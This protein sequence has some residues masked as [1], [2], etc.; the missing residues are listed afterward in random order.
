MNDSQ[1]HVSTSDSDVGREFEERT[2]KILAQ[3]GLRLDA[4]HD[5]P[6]GLGSVTKN[7]AFDLRSENPKVIVECESHTWTSGR[8]LPSAKM[9]NWAEVMFHMAPPEY[10]TIFF[11]ERSVC[12]ERDETLLGHFLCAQAHMVPPDVEFWEL[13]SDGELAIHEVRR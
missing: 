7:H 12:H 1:R 9:E 5:I 3:Q 2:Q 13:S 10:G 11:V 4:L 8:N 6:C